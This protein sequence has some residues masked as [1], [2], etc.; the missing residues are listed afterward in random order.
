MRAE[1]RRVG[2]MERLLHLRTLPIL[3]TLSPEDLGLV[4]EQARTRIFRKGDR[5]LRQ[6]EP[7]GS[8]HILVEGRVDLRRG[9]QDLGR[10]GPGAGVGGLGYLSRDPEGVE[11]V[12]ETDVVAL[13]LDGDTLDEIL[14]DR[15]PVLQHILRETSRGLIDL[16]HEAPREC[17]EA[18]T[19]ISAPGF[20]SPLD[21]VQRML[22]L[23]EGLPF[24]R[25]SASA[26]A[27][28]ARG[29]VELR[30]EKGTVLWRR[31]EPGRQV[32]ML[33]AGRVSCASP[34]QDFCLEPEPGFPLGGL[35]AVAGVPR[36][37][38]AVCETPVVT[39]SGN[40]EILFDL[41]EDN[42]DVALAYLAQV[43]RVHLDVLERIVAAGR[44]ASLLPFFG[45]NT[46]P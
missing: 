2:R 4:A 24:I 37:Y 46:D 29:L 28:L 26:L 21:L 10:A 42:S 23:R 11:A 14:E 36:W 45:G 6:G 8:V 41:F 15:F 20:Q 12:A 22:F 44:E 16:W 35:D 40:A 27:D 1:D 18:Q 19:R 43:S 7:I 31:G 25:A 33:V 17:L 3:G 38:D 5:L 13:E 9:N 34:I 32:Q 39:L 30:F